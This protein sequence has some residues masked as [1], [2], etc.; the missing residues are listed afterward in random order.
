MAGFALI[1]NE[2]EWQ[3]YTRSCETENDI[4]PDS[5]NFGSG[6]RQYPCIAASVLLENNFFGTCY[7][8]LKDAAALV[9]ACGYDVIGV[10]APEA[11]EVPGHTSKEFEKHVSAMLM[12][13]VHEMMSVRITHEER[14]E[15]VLAEMLAKVDQFHAENKAAALKAAVMSQLKPEV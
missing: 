13:I 12:A 14:F 6:P 8:Y 7:F 3:V 1:R 10:P 4:V 15:A 5:A 2:S 9:R 11:N